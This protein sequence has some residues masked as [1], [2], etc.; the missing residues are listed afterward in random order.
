MLKLN[1]KNKLEINDSFMPKQTDIVIMKSGT[2]SMVANI[3]VHG[4]KLIT[5][6]DGNRWNEKCNTLEEIRDYIIKNQLEVYR[7]SEL[8]LTLGRRV[9]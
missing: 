6:K 2:V 4:Y 7:D 1:I 3:G 5:L 9:K 8:D